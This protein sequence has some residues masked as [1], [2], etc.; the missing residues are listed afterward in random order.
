MDYEDAL[1]LWGASKL[2]DQAKA[3]GNRKERII[4]LNTVTVQI[5]FD[6]GYYD[7]YEYE[8]D[9]ATC[10]VMVR[11]TGYRAD[12]VDRIPSSYTYMIESSTFIFTDFLK[13]VL[14]FAT[15]ANA[16]KL[17]TAKKVIKPK[18]NPNP[19]LITHAYGWD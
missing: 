5:E 4:D 9:D 16:K 7:G 6:P 12:G 10:H 2:A 11:G 8:T 14:A 18:F 19:Q 15:D 3:Y 13:E 17:L 1:R